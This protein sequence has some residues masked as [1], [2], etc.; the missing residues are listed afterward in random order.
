[1][2]IN[3]NLSFLH[4]TLNVNIAACGIGSYVRWISV[5]ASETE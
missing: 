1:M 3:F 4:D 5:K 2:L